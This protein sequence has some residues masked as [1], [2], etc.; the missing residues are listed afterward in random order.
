MN[1]IK[2]E[3]WHNNQ[4]YRFNGNR[5]DYSHIMSKTKGLQ[6]KYQAFAERINA[7]GGYFEIHLSD[8]EGM[9]NGIHYE[10][11]IKGISKGLQ[12]DIEQSIPSNW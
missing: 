1:E 10:A 3:Y 8:S 7:E 11:L 4:P 12:A 9:E 5:F 2:V 6:E